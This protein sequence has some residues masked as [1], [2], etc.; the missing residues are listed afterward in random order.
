[1]SSDPKLI[2]TL[3]DLFHANIISNDQ[4][5]VLSRLSH[6]QFKYHLIIHIVRARVTSGV[7]KITSSF[8]KFLLQNHHY[9]TLY[10]QWK[11]LGKKISSIQI[12]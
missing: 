11:E 8:T 1:M 12:I 2:M 4:V 7:H 5:H 9:T 6:E 10:N 3:V